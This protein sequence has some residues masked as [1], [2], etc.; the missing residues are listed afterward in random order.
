MHDILSIVYMITQFRREETPP[1]QTS[2]G[3]SQGPRLQWIWCTHPGV[4]PHQQ[5]KRR[6]EKAH[7]LTTSQAVCG[8]SNHPRCSG[9]ST[10]SAGPD[11]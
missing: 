11:G 9:V 6:F 10:H 1:S 4:K 3:T 7:K 8:L 2:V 5:I